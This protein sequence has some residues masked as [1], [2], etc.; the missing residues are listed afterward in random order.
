MQNTMR[1]LGAGQISTEGGVDVNK[2]HMVY[3]I[4]FFLFGKPVKYVIHEGPRATR[5]EG[6]KAPGPQGMKVW[7]PPGHS[8]LV[9]FFMPWHVPLVML[10]F[11]YC[12]MFVV[13][14]AE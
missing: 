10:C 2:G 7:R 9:N 1:A 5:Y 3:K 13:F 8:Y 4:I 6:M 11:V 12:I 14:Y